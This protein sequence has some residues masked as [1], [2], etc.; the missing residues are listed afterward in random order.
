MTQYAPL[1]RKDQERDACGVGFVAD[2]SGKRSYRI[3]DMALQCVTNLT[4]R[5]AL[6]A[7]AKTGDG[8]GVLFQLPAA[9]FAGEAAKLGAPV[10]AADIGVA[11]AFLP[12]DERAAG[13]C[14]QALERAAEREGLRALGWRAVPIDPSV[15]GEIAQRSQPRMEQLLLARRQGMSDDDFERALFLARKEAERE[16]ADAGIDGFYVPSMSHRTIVYKGLLVAYQLNK[17]YQ[18]LRNPTFETALALFHQRYSTNTLPNWV[19]SQPFRM[20]A[21]NGEINTL[22][23]NKNWQRAREPELHS[24]LWGEEIERLKP[25]IQDEDGSD[26]AILDN[27]L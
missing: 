4:H 12:Q 17:F 10:D 14:H 2:V 3:L 16:T 9:F 1:Y 13:L 5:G 19:L 21:H 20:L 27:V 24:S 8:A 25:V 6:D 15:L 18:D 22:Q 23:G 11:M 26:S 7:D